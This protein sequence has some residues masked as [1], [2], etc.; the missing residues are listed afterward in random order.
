MSKQR[1]YLVHVQF[2]AVELKVTAT[3]EADAKRKAKVKVGKRSI[4]KLID[5]RNLWADYYT[6]PS[7]PYFGPGDF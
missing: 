5:T 3:S 7:T 6:P 4:T 2:H 1:D